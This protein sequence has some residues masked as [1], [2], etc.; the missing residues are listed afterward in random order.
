MATNPW[1]RAGFDAW[2]LG[3]EASSVI[4]LRMLKIGAGGA[5]GETEA[6]QMVSEKIASGFALQAMALTGGLGFTAHG[7]ARKT[8]AHY[9]RKVRANRRRLAKR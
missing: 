7:A 4:A 2:S 9:R 8:L 1:V 5:A 6:R 3:V